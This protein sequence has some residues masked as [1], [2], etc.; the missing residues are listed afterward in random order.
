[1]TMR[2]SWRF[3]LPQV[4]ILGGLFVWAGVLWA[5][6]SELQVIPIRWDAQGQVTAYGGRFQ[7]LLI[8]PLVALAT[9]LLLRFA[10][11]VDPLRANYRLFG[12]AYAILRLAIVAALG[13]MGAVIFLSASGLPVDATAAT[14]AVLGVLFTVMGA[15]MGKI[16]PNWFIGIRTPWTMT[17][18]TS[19][20]RTHRLAGYVFLAI[21]LAFLASI[22]FRTTVAITLIVAF[23]V[24]ASIGLVVYSYLVWRTDP[25]RTLALLS[26]PAD[27][28][29]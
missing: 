23:A 27:D 26:R 14:K 11:L 28:Q 25:D 15:L 9:Y 29:A 21:G 24:A 7:A 1:M 22:P 17:S 8:V 6:S 12:D 18:K 10:P 13:A 4:L 19:W 2:T 3:E 5:N 20:V 16:R